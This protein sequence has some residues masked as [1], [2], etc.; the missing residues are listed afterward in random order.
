[1]RG[2]LFVALA[3]TPA[4]AGASCPDA[5]MVLADLSL[6]EDP[7]LTAV[8]QGY[9]D[10]SAATAKNG[11]LVTLNGYRDYAAVLAAL[12]NYNLGER[13]PDTVGFGC[14]EVGAELSL[15]F[16]KPSNPIRIMVATPAASG[17]LKAEMLAVHNRLRCQHGAPPLVWSDEV[18]AY[19]QAW[20]E[21]DGPVSGQHSDAFNS[22]IGPLGENMASGDFRDYAEVVEM[23]YSEVQWYDFE[24]P[25]TKPTVA[26]KPVGH[27]TAMIWSD[28]KVLGCGQSGKKFSCNY[29]NG[30]T[31]KTCSSVNITSDGRNNCYA[32]RVLPVD[33]EA[34]CP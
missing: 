1:M 26:G 3:S 24:N 10:S 17:D 30:E 19:A 28:A 32:T 27:F 6:T 9:A 18:A 31:K 4:H 33:P 20:A 8:A 16:V 22:P 11:N 15:Y 13:Y 29:W 2:W 12:Q 5:A 23:W 34:V 14:R 21:G 7:T 25:G